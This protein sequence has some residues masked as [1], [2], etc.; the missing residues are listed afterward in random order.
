MQKA[1]IYDVFKYTQK[2]LADISTRLH[3]AERG[4]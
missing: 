3:G 4:I 1:P 2:S